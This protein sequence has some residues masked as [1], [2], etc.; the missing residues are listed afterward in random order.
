MATWNGL[1]R[2]KTDIIQPVMT[3]T[4]PQELRDLEH[5]DPIVECRS[6][7][8]RGDW[9]FLAVRGYSISIPGLETNQSLWGNSS[10][11]RVIAGTSD[12]VT[13][14]EQWRLQFVAHKFA[15]EFNLEMA[16][17]YQMAKRSLD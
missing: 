13:S 15:T 5:Q 7:V 11:Q 3:E 6:A 14:E 4:I 16:K 12:Y 9:R 1:K 10:L 8:K 2:T 17:Q